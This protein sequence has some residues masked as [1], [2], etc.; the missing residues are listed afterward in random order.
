MIRVTAMPPW[1]TKG[2]LTKYF[3]NE[4]KSGGGNIEKM[5]FYGNQAVITFENPEVIETVLARGHRLLGADLEV[6]EFTQ[7]SP[8]IPH[9]MSTL[10]QAKDQHT[11]LGSAKEVRLVLIGKTGSGKSA[12]GNTIL[13]RK[14]F[15][16][17]LSMGSITKKCCFKR[18]QRFGKDI[19]VV[20]TPGLFDTSISNEETMKEATKCIELC[21]PGPHAIILVIS[22]GRFTKEE[23]DT[24][25]SFSEIF[26][27]G[28]FN[29]M[30]V[31]FTR[32]DDLKRTGTTLQECVEDTPELKDILE[33]CGHRCLAFDNTQSDEFRE[34]D[35]MNLIKEV[36]KII[37]AHEGNYYTNDMLVQ[38]EKEYQRRIKEVVD[39]KNREIE[40]A[41]REI[42]HLRQQNEMLEELEKRYR[43]KLYSLREQNR[44]EIEEEKRQAYRS[45]SGSSC[46]IQ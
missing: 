10:S 20:D 1:T 9:P 3:E 7:S 32:G 29:H 33:K 38:A 28:M 21:L 6:K 36:E 19:I 26:G 15:S 16:S 22:F 41:T 5:D 43:A 14:A 12:T 17:K 31:V 27:Q 8:T 44:R 18:A 23:Q 40:K 4:R 24:V 25:T 46:N 2:A 35:A 34:K 30:I 13:G 11:M 45:K 37:S 39:E 42:A